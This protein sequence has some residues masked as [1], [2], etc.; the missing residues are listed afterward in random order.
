MS[1]EFHNIPFNEDCD[2]HRELTEIKDELNIIN[3]KKSPNGNETTIIL[4]SLKNENFKVN[5]D[6]QKYNKVKEFKIEMK[7]RL[8]ILADKDIKMFFRGKI[9][10]D[11]K[12]LVDYSNL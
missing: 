11:D 3:K 8:G 1:N 4:R 5:I 6:M 7:N 10:E 2:S 12:P 9:F